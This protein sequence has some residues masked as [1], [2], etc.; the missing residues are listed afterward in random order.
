MNESGQRW[1]REVGKRDGTKKWEREMGQRQVNKW[2]REVGQ[3]SSTEK[4]QREWREKQVRLMGQRNWTKK[5]NSDRDIGG[6][7]LSEDRK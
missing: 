6:K 2:D 1:D 7:I 4:L 5:K 3:N